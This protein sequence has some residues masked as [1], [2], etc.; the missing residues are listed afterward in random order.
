MPA[1]W[2]N[3]RRSHDGPSSPASTAADKDVISQSEA[4]VQGVAVGA[5]DG[6]ARADE[7]PGKG[8]S[9]GGDGGGVAEGG[10]GDKAT[11]LA[12]GTFGVDYMFAL[13]DTVTGKV[14]PSPPCP[15]SVPPLLWQAGGEGES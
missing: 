6:Q 5:G 10:G 2:G 9:S 14:L 7:G 3:P 8:S 12:D 15:G 1:D 4:D 13:A 11:A